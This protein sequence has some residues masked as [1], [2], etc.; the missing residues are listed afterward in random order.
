MVRVQPSPDFEKIMT[1]S[2]EHAVHMLPPLEVMVSDRKLGQV[3]PMADTPTEFTVKALL[4]DGTESEVRVF[5]PS[6]VTAVPT[7]TN[8]S[9]LVVLVY[10]GGFCTG[11][12]SHMAR[13]ARAI[14]YLLGVTVANVSYRL[15]PEHKFP[16]CPQDVWDSL[17]WLTITAAAASRS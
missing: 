6:G 2:R 11:H 3:P 4:R 17:S 8:K 16:Q 10:G 1:G 14:A 9:A 15:A 13:Y 12:W 7:T 5:K